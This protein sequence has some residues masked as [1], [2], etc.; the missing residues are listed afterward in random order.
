MSSDS[1]TSSRSR[2]RR[3]AAT[4]RDPAATQPGGEHAP[5]RRRLRDVGELGHHRDRGKEE[6]DRRDPA[7]TSSAS[8]RGRSRV[9]EHERRRRPTAACVPDPYSCLQGLRA[10]GRCVVCRDAAST[11]R[12]QL[13]DEPA[14]RAARRLRADPRRAEAPGGSPRRCWPRPRRRR[15]TGAARP[16][17]VTDL[18]LPHHRPARARPTS[19]RRCTSSAARAASGCATRSPTSAPSSARAARSTPRPTAGSRP[20]TART[21]ARRCTRPSLS[22]GA[23]SCCPTRC[24]RPCCGPSTSTPTAS[25]PRPTYDGRWCG[26][27]D[28]STTR[29]VQQLVD[30]GTDDERLLLLR[31]VGKL[32]MQLEVERGGVSACRSPSRRSSRTATRSAWSTA[33]RCPVESGTS[34]SR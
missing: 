27:A 34:R 18:P 3:P 26:R 8:S 4:A 5:R 20:S 28:R 31:E 19:T 6:Q 25:R 23:A 16:R 17:T 10:C 15:S 7:R 22:E 29:S 24:G 30:G 13:Q 11:P 2:A 32:R 12:V 14:G 9:D 33:P 1:T 21:S